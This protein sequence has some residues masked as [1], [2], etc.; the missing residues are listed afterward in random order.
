MRFRLVPKSMTL[1]DLEGPLCNLFQNTCVLGAHRLNLNEGAHYQRR[2]RSPM[3]LVS[4]NMRFFADIRRG[5]LGD[6]ALNG[7]E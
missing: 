7:S 5:F 2:R 1:D 6:Q 4:G 3:T